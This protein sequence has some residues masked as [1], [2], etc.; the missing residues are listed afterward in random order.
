MLVVSSWA[1]ALELAKKKC[2][3]RLFAI[4]HSVGMWKGCNFSNV[5]NAEV[6]S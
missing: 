2:V 1:N 4:L 5:I 6:E 3:F